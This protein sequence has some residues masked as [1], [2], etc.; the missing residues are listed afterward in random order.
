M[1]GWP[2][3]GQLNVRIAAGFKLSSI[4]QD[5]TK[6]DPFNIAITM[7]NYFCYLVHYEIISLLDKNGKSIGLL[8][9]TFV[10]SLP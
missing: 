7:P 2:I 9:L 8:C 6:V 10:F 4:D 3:L 1:P 5:A